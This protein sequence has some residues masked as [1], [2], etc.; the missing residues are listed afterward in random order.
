[1]DLSLSTLLEVS[2]VGAGVGWL[3]ALVGIG[4]GIV[5]VP[6]LVLV[7]DVPTH[8]AI[9]TSLISVVATSAAAGSGTRG[10]GLANMRLGLALEIATTIGAIAGGL[11]SVWISATALAAIFGVVMLLTTGLMLLSNRRLAKVPPPEDKPAAKPKVLGWEDPGRL[12]GAYFDEHEQKMV[13]YRA[14]RLSIGA[15]VSLIAGAL[16]GMLGVGG[17][18]LKVPAMS[19]GMRVPIRV[20]A[21]TSSFMIGVTALA[22]LFVYYAHG[23]VHP[24]LAAPIALGALGGSFV[25]SRHSARVPAA[26]LRWVLSVILLFV[27]VQMI[28]RAFGVRLV[29]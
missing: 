22:S 16:S 13:H 21:A 8:V 27:A 28:L 9:A 1:M 12:A 29:H 11:V 10:S 17:G 25:G 4:G 26:T 20:A 3:G 18:F 15:G 14:E 19:L 24:F 5:L 2:V 6:A 23:Y 7:F